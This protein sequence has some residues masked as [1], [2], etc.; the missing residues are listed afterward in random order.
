MQENKSHPTESRNAALRLHMQTDYSAKPGV[1]K[2]GL[3]QVRAYV[4]GSAMMLEGVN[5]EGELVA[6][7]RAEALD[8]SLIV[9]P[10]EMA[11]ACAK[12]RAAREIEGEYRLGGYHGRGNA[13]EKRAKIHNTPTYKFDGKNGHFIE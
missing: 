3:R 4:E 7:S 9:T 13:R 10:K 2:L 12:L 1:R 11:A 5:A 8:A 6:M